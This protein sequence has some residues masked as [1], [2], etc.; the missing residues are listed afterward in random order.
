MPEPRRIHRSATNVMSVAMI[1]VGI[2]V[3]IRTIAAGGGPV[4]T[5]ILLGALFIFGGVMR[6]YVQT[7][8]R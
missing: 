6:L 1:V 5:G 2:A 7:R 3:I 8:M 4:S